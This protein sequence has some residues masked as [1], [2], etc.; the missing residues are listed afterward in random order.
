MME[1][2]HKYH[3]DRI[4]EAGKLYDSGGMSLTDFVRVVLGSPSDRLCRNTLAHPLGEG[5]RE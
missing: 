1:E 3:A 4:D 2:E 5:A